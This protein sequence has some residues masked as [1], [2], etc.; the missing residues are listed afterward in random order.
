MDPKVYEFGGFR[1]NCFEKC[2]YQEG[3][4]VNLTP[5]ALEI[6]I[7]L[8]EQAGELAPKEVLIEKVWPGTFVEENNLSQQISAL[9]KVLGD[10]E[11]IETVPR[12]GFRFQ[13]PVRTVGPPPRQHLWARRTLLA[14]PLGGL[15]TAMWW[16][17]RK[18]RRQSTMAVLPFLNLTGNS[19]NDFLCDGLTEQVIDGLAKV[20]GLQVLARTSAFQYRGQQVDIREL[21]GKLGVEW[22]LEGSVR[23]Q[24]DTL[25]V[26]AQLIRSTDNMHVWSETFERPVADLYQLQ[27]YVTERVVLQ[28]HLQQI[29]RAK[30]RAAPNSEAYQAYLRG[31]KAWNQG[32]SKGYQDAIRYFE[33]ATRR[34]PDFAAAYAGLADT[35]WRSALWES[36]LPAE[37]YGWAKKAVETALQLDPTSSEAHASNGQILLNYDFKI[38]EAERALKRVLELDPVNANAHHWLS[39]VMIPQSRW[40]ESRAYSETALRYEPEDVSIRNHMGWHLYHAGQ[41]EEGRQWTERV[42]Q[43]RPKFAGARYFLALIHIELGNLRNA[44]ASLKRSLELDGPNPERQG[45]LGYVVGRLGDAVAARKIRRQL[46]DDLSKRHVSRRSFAL[47]ALGLGDTDEAFRQLDMAAEQRSSL[48]V[49]FRVD[50]LFASL[51]GDQ[52]FDQIVRRCGGA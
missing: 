33:E 15:G 34:Q 42:I 25:R 18:P 47:I 27:D 31:R 19:E 5:K 45:A 8:V 12:R 48:M 22:V 35:Y 30:P 10:P 28:I 4:P 40:Q 21:S 38:A 16:V 11:S 26:T 24:G 23:R 49:N 13:L 3:K 14:L 9:R 2:L 7:V 43:W 20:Q 32:T 37:S 44:A 46:E 1:L 41:F 29:P 51:R 17:L 6:L 52:R 39:H 50:P 36:A